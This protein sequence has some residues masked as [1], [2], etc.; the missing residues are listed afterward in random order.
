MPMRMSGVSIASAMC[1]RNGKVPSAGISGMLTL[2]STAVT[3]GIVDADIPEISCCWTLKMR[4]GLDCLRPTISGWLEEIADVEHPE[5]AAAVL[6]KV[7]IP[8]TVMESVGM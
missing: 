1:R 6:M 8:S 7:S 5:S 3:T 2:R 4:S